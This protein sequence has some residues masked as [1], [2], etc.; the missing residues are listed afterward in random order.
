MNDFQE[1]LSKLGISGTLYKLYVAAIELGEA[2]ISDVATRAGL[3]RTT[4]YDAL[5]RLEEEGLV[6]VVKR[7]S[8]RI[9]IAEDPAVLLERLESRR[10][11][12]GDVM[13]ELRS[14]Y[15]RAKGKPRIRYYEGR[16]G[17]MTA[18][19]DTLTVKSSEPVLRGILSM[20]ELREVPGLEEMERFID[21]RVGKGIWLRVI[22][23]RMKDVA[24]IWPSSSDDLRSLRYTPENVLLSMTTFIYDTRVCLISSVRENY[25]MIIESEEFAAMQSQL[26]EALWEMSDES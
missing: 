14:L 1:K 7:G 10:Q 26:F 21:A 20:D 4:A 9:V 18:L 12:L 2:P 6:A 17:I 8:K 11:M 16:D 25:G 15:N 24:P 23:S 19:R 22:R 3:V 5:S 13:P